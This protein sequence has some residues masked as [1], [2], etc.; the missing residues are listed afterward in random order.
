MT[1]LKLLIAL[2]SLGT[3]GLAGAAFGSA[4]PASTASTVVSTK[5]T[6]LGTT[7]VNGSGQTL[8]LDTADKP[9]H[10]ACTGAC[11]K[12]WPALK[13]IGTVKAAGGAK[14]SLLGATKGP[15]GKTVTYNGHPLYTFISDTKSNPT[16]GEGQ[17]GFY[18]LSS[19][20]N[21]I[22]KPAPKKKPGGQVPGY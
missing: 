12:T 20:G 4:A 14:A 19:M 16:S 17:R 2:S 7:L 13:A 22:T 10:F 3:L 15:A 6:S 8:Y 11:L 1:R 21:K 5:Q 9:P 18:V